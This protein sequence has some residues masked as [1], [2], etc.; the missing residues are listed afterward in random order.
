MVEIKFADI[1]LSYE[2]VTIVAQIMYMITSWLSDP[3]KNIKMNINDLNIEETEKLREEL[4]DKI[5]NKI[6]EDEPMES[7]VQFFY[8]NKIKLVVSASAE[9]TEL[10][11]GHSGG[12]EF[13]RT[14]SR[15]IEMRGWGG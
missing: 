2:I 14:A 3:L 11:K 10:Y 9:P 1:L 13:N 15:L 8:E 12:F 5:A 4:L 6:T 7:L